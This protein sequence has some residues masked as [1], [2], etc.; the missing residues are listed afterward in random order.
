MPDMAVTFTAPPSGRV[1]VRWSAF[2]APGTGVFNVA[3]YSAGTQIGS[4]EQISQSVS[5]YF[6]TNHTWLMTG[7]TSGTSY[8]FTPYVYN[9]TSAQ[10]SYVYYGGS[11]GIT[12]GTSNNGPAITEVWSA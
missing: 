12:T 3:L 5:L 7:L 9:A 8:T 10:T 11:G 6:R 2:I 4:M 1:L